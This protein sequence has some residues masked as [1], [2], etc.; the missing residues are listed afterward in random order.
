VRDQHDILV[1]GYRGAE[2]R[3]HIF[4]GSWR[5]FREWHLDGPGSARCQQVCHLMPAGRSGQRAWQQAQHWF[6]VQKLADPGSDEPD[7]RVP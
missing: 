3:E 1:A 2:P 4:P 7:R 5:T 6:H